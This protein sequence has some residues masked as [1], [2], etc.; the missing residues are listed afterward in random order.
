M[1]DEFS[2]RLHESICLTKKHNIAVLIEGLGWTYDI[3]YNRKC[4]SPHRDIAINQLVELNAK[5]IDLRI[6]I[7]ECDAN[8]R[9]VMQFKVP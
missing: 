7:I 4:F 8:G 2:D 9:P 5:Q 6:N 3:T 1:N